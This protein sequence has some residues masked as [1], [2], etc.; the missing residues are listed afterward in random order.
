DRLRLRD[1]DFLLS[2]E[3]VETPRTDY[4]NHYYGYSYPDAGPYQRENA[5]G[6]TFTGLREGTGWET[7]EAGVIR[8][9]VTEALYWLG[10]VD[11]G[12]AEGRVTAFRIT[13]NGGRL[14]HDEAAAAF[15]DPAAPHVVIQPSF[16]V[17][18]FPPTGEADLFRLDQIAERV[19]AE[20]A[21]EY[22][23]TPEA[24]YRAQQGGQELD[25]IVGFLER[26]G[27]VPLPQNVRRSLEEW[28]ARHQRITVR[29]GVALLQA[30]DGAVLDALLADPEL[31]P[32]L[33]RRLT[34]TAAL[35]PPANLGRLYERLLAVERLPALSEGNDLLPRPVYRIDA[36]GRISFRQRLPS[37][38]VLHALRP[39]AE[40]GEQD[41]S[42]DGWRLTRESLR[43]GARGGLGAEA[44]IELLARYH[45]GP[46][47]D[48]VRAMVKRWA[49][50]WGKGALVDAVMLQVERPELLAD[51]LADPALA[52]HL[53]PVPA[54]ATL[55]V[56]RREGLEAVR[57]ALTE[58]DM[59]LRASFFR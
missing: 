24:L 48:E 18:A 6:V 58:R 28:G 15:A 55:A 56:V 16:Q 12:L 52:P 9:I 36:G 54:A 19:R 27:A 31:G 41:E 7:V 2:R 42:A 10:L 40:G 50:D 37:L 44:I 14:L 21:I 20:Q 1:Y 35:V 5:L 8:V 26:V 25:E 46:L 4:Y 23:L 11:L 43:R 38:H 59:R 29:R 34:P 47:S 30:V 49:K 3:V 33:G 51:L 39:V 32:L 22:E 17:F 57:A 13:E 45:H 53:S